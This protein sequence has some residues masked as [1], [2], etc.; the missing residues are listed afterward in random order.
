MFNEKILQ[1][2]N[3]KPNGESIYTHNNN[4]INI[5]NQIDDIYNINSETYEHLVNVCKI[6]DIGKAHEEFQNNITSTKRKVRHEMLSASYSDL[7]N[8]ERIA[9]LLHHKDIETIN[10]NKLKAERYYSKFRSDLENTLKINTIDIFSLITELKR[11]MLC[12]VLKEKNLIML[13]GYL[14]LCD[15]LASAGV[16]KIDIGLDTYE[17]LGLKKNQIYNSIQVKVNQ[18]MNICD[19]IIQAPTGLGKTKTAMYWADKIQN[20]NKSRRIYYILPYTASINAKYKEF[21]DAGI[22]T[23]MMHGKAQYFLNK[24]I[25]DSENFKSIYQ[26]FK[27]SVK[28]VTVCTIYQLFK[29]IFSCKNF[30]MLLCQMKNSIFIVDEIHCFDIK[31]LALILSTLKYLKDNWNI[32]ICIMSASIP[33]CLIEVI[34]EE[35]GIDKVIKAD[36]EDFKIRHK[37]HYINDMLESNLGM[38]KRDLDNG[39]R[40]LVCVNSVEL[41]QRLFEKF[42]EYESI[43]LIHG[44]FNTRDREIIE[45]NLDKQK[46]LI[47]T[48]AIEVSLDIDYDV[49]YTEMAP[50][51]SLL[52]RFGRIYRTGRKDEEG[53]WK[54]GDIYIFKSTDNI[55]KQD[56]IEKTRM[57][58][59]DIIEN[60]DGV[61]N[62]SEVGNYL[63]KV[64]SEI[65][66]SEY[67]DKKR[68]ILSIIDELRVGIYNKSSNMIEDCGESVLP[69]SLLD[70]YKVYI[71][72]RNYLSA[73]C[74]LVDISDKQFRFLRNSRMI[75]KY[76]KDMGVY[77]VYLE[78]NK[79]GEMIG[80]T[81]KEDLE[82][83]DI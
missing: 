45:K 81:N 73:N 49:L 14:Q 27:K 77:V 46:L 24:E 2:Y 42:K 10:Y 83:K 35:L 66:T 18:L 56:I 41:S 60:N 39:K 7:T 76:N 36:N 13:K 72:S 23:A 63:D 33:K 57:V 78:Y 21:K 54:T 55:Y 15:H 6:H 44:K 64:Y 79:N 37:I 1:K 26:L 8:N 17:S 59:L 80:L 29:S 68:Q 52:Q 32:N 62:E 4:L 43:K 31:Q 3:A 65:D 82:H 22:S 67:L 34:Q 74:L 30:E 48:Q 71:E 61:I 69:I 28:Q 5:L 11:S 38:I 58:L 19:I 50:I 47:G 40:V 51:D 75:S 25:K 20:K 53:N 70:E 9:I 12:D 16:K